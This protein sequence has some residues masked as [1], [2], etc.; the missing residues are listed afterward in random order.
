MNPY[1]SLCDECGVTLYLHSK[2]DMPTGRETV[3]HFFE[4]IQKVQ[5]S[6]TEFE[7]RAEEDYFLQEDRESGSYRW[8]SL[9]RRRLCCG[10]VNP[11][12]LEAADEHITRILELAP[13]HLDLSGLQTESLDV[14]YH[15]DLVYQGNHDQLVLEAIAS[16]TP[17]EALSQMPGASVLHYQP[18]LQ[19]ALDDTFQ[20]QA[21]LHIETRTNAYH[22]RNGQASADTPI[23]LYLT[24]RQLWNKQPFASFIDSYHNQR[25]ILEELMQ[26]TVLPQVLQP[27]ARAINLQ[28]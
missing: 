14:M 12:A 7:K 11:P 28:Q 27:L 21:R 3:L 13:F 5:P 2:L 22:L 24:V 20:L 17:L 6:M 23:S 8:A 26:G 1:A 4:A 18:I 19:L 15:F 10:F 16:G 25:R 9:D